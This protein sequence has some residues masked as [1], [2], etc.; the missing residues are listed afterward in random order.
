MLTVL[1]YIADALILGGYFMMSKS[2]SRVTMY[3]WINLGAN[4]I[5]VPYDLKYHAPAAA[6]LGIA[7]FLIS[8]YGLV[9]R[10]S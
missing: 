2:H 9:R 3:N 6:A 4:F 5:L 8:L 10:Y 1:A 7:F